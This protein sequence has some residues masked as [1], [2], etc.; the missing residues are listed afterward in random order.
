M[1]YYRRPMMLPPATGPVETPVL[2]DDQDQQA[3]EDVLV[4]VVRRLTPISFGVQ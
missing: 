2:R 1:M 3:E 4:P